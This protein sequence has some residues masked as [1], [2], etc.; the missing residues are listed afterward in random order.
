[1]DLVMKVP[2]LPG[3][4]EKEVAEFVGRHAGRSLRQLRLRRRQ[5][6]DAGGLTGDRR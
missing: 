3:H 2:R 1:M 4:G 5:A 6:G